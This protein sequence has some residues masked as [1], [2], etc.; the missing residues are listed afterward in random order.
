MR[1]LLVILHAQRARGGAEAYTLQLFHALHKAGHTPV[2]AAASFDDDIPAHARV[3]LSHDGF[4]RTGRYLSFLN[5]L[6]AHVSTTQY[7][8]I[9]AMLPVRRCDVYHPHAGIAARETG[10]LFNPRRRAFAC[11]ERALLTSNAPPVVLSLSS[12]IEAELA[13][14]YPH[15]SGR[16]ERLMNAVDLNYFSPAAKK[17]GRSTAHVVIVAQDFV[18]K[19]VP[20]LFDAIRPLSITLS[21]VGAGDMPYW[22]KKI[23]RAGLTD[24]VKCV[25]P[26]R[27]V[28]PFYHEADFFVLPTR[29]D[30]CSLVVLEALACGL[31]VITTKQNGAA[32]VITHGTHGYVLD[33]TAPFFINE[34]THAMDRLSDPHTRTPMI[35]ACLSLR[36]SL[37][38]RHHFERLLSI[39]RSVAH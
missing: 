15:S 7:D 24:R 23:A 8:V 13:A 9:H 22:N 18:R 4:T 34:L 20:A 5:A 25:G 10:G 11:V 16:F 26:Q 19:G 35:D 14:A 31:P 17:S 38:Y 6:D 37:S 33:R 1:I 29:H 12:Y 27:D 36:D 3:L 28:R 21:I 2:L 32:D 39:Y 30:P